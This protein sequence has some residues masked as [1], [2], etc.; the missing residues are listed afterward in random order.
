MNQEMYFNSVILFIYMIKFMFM[1][2]KVFSVEHKVKLIRINE[3][4]K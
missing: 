3:I 2:N 4:D 1:I